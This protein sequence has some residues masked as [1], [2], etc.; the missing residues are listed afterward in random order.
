[1]FR[2]HIEFRGRDLFYVIPCNVGSI[3]EV[4]KGGISFIFRC[5]QLS[6]IQSYCRGLRNICDFV[7]VRQDAGH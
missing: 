5:R 2:T 6:A 7:F 1:M 3:P 4:A